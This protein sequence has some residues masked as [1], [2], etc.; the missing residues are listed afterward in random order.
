LIEFKGK[1]QGK[2]VLLE[3]TTENEVRLNRFEIERSANGYAYEK[4]GQLSATGNGNARTTYSYTDA[5]I[6]NAVNFYRLKMIDADGKYS[7]SHVLVFTGDQLSGAVV[8]T[9]A[10]NPFTES[11]KVNIILEKKQ[12]IQV[13]LAD[14]SGRIIFTKDVS[15]QEGNNSIQCNGLSSLQ[16]GIYFLEVRTAGGRIQQKILKVN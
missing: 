1:K 12:S 15:G 14:V 13:K 6:T 5:N 9:A 8:A 7:Y 11:F 4:I 10:P 16:Q 3:W 2:S